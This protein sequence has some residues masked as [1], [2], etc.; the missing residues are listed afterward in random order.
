MDII[1][2]TR[3]H[4]AQVIRLGNHDNFHG[5]WPEETLERLVDSP[6]DAVLVAIDQSAMTG[7]AI[8]TYHEPTRKAMFENLLVD[9]AYRHTKTCHLLVSA[10][11]DF[12]REIGASTIQAQVTAPKLANYLCR[13]G[14]KHYGQPE[15]VVYHV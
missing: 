2:A 15:W 1:Q 12:Y 9:P 4:I 5:F 10:L 11:C 6:N 3:N 14:F 7:F 8:G 13:K